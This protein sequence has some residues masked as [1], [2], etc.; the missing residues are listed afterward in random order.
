MARE[1]GRLRSTRPCASRPRSPVSG[2]PAGWRDRRRRLGPRSLAAFRQ[3]AT[4]HLRQPLR[5]SGHRDPGAGA[6]RRPAQPGRA[7]RL[8]PGWSPRVRRGSSVSTTPRA[9][10][11]WARTGT[12]WL[13]TFP[14]AGSTKPICTRTPSGARTTGWSFP[15]VSCSPSRGARLSGTAPACSPRPGEAGSSGANVTWPTMAEP[16]WARAV[17]ATGQPAALSRL[18]A[19]GPLADAGERARDRGAPRGPRRL[20]GPGQGRPRLGVVLE[21]RGLPAEPARGRDPR[22]AVGQARGR[23]CYPSLLPFGPDGV[24][25]RRRPLRHTGVLRRPL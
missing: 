22:R 12:S 20:R 4:G 18:A 5:R 19:G 8:S 16:R 2:A 15:V 14:P 13:F 11:R 9:P 3:D 17:T 23:L 25:E 6:G 24:R 10:S 1:G 7:P 21:D